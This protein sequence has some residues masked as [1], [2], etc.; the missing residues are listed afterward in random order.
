MVWP[1]TSWY[2]VST[3]SSSLENDALSAMADIS[4]V[5][6]GMVAHRVPLLHHALH[7]LRRR[8]QIMSHHKEGGRNAVLF[9]RIPGSAPC[10]RF[11]SRHQRSGTGSSPRRPDRCSSRRCTPAVSAPRHCPPAAAP[12]AESSAPSC[13]RRRL[14]ARL[15]S[16]GHTDPHSADGQ[17]RHSGH[18]SQQLP[19][20]DNPIHSRSPPPLPYAP[21][22][23]EY[24]I[25]PAAISRARNAPAFF[26]L[27]KS[28]KSAYNRTE[29]K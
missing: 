7:Q 2:R 17:C 13:P 25:F 10:S 19:P 1:V 27:A 12:A 8:F 18:G 6:V 15:P 29:E 3:P 22:Q 11:R 28:G 24:A 16:T 20:F 23:G 9:Q 14:W 4:G 21:G 5:V 26:L